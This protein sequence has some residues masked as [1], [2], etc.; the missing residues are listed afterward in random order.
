MPCGGTKAQRPVIKFYTA[1][2]FGE[3]SKSQIAFCVKL[4]MRYHPQGKEMKRDK[5]V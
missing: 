1:V 5:T 3:R 2:N 4:Y